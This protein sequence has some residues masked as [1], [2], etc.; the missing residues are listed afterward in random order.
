MDLALRKEGNEI[1]YELDKSYL[2]NNKVNLK[3]YEPEVP[4]PGD[5][6]REV[7]IVELMRPE[8]SQCGCKSLSSAYFPNVLV[9]DTK[10]H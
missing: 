6:A 3:G 4:S 9:L 8:T 10:L 7:E 2:K 1:I 5:T